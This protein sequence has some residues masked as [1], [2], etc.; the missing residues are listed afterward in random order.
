MPHILGPIN[1]HLPYM[2]LGVEPYW[3]SFR[4]SI[5]LENPYFSIAMMLTIHMVIFWSWAFAGHL[6]HKNGWFE[7]LRIQK[8]KYPSD[9]LVGKAVKA[10]LTDQFLVHPILGYLCRPVFTLRSDG[11]F[12][13]PLPT[14]PEAVVQFLLCVSMQD[15]FF[16]W[17]HRLLHHPSIYKHIHKQHH[18]FY[19]PTSI[20]SEYAH[21]IEGIFGNL[22]PIFAGP[23][24]F[25]VHETVFYF[26]LS[27]A[28][29]EA[30]SGH[31]G[32]D[33]PHF[34]CP[35]SLIPGLH[36]SPISHD[37]HHSHNIELY[38]GHTIF[39]DWIMG[40]DKAW[41]KYQMEKSEK[42][43]KLT[44]KRDGKDADFS[45]GKRDDK[46]D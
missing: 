11:Y 40:T 31:S 34:F 13:G 45:T 33:I 25:N 28:I 36:S 29:G 22:V 18:T 37:Y 32:L 9:E 6:V 20:G 1:R 41:K 10:A 16:Y 23:L 7:S 43:E 44:Q 2:D 4:R 19:T 5:P 15:L 21:P 39:W 46:V 17:T 24:L 3:W 35:V 26:W 42:L 27:I 14:F 30:Q 38:G 12:F 8:G